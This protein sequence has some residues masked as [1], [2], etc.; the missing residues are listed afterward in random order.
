MASLD[1]QVC[2]I[3]ETPGHA[4]DRNVKFLFVWVA[5]TSVK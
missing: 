4:G 3:G 1:T 5:S 2:A